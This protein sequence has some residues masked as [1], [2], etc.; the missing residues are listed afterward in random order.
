MTMRREKCE[1]E[2]EVVMVV[3]VETNGLLRRA[4]GAG[5]GIA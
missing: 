4:V 2:A 5:I 3:V 1:V